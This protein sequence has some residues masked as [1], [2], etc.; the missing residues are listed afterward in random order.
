MSDRV[1]LLVELEY[2]AAKAGKKMT[3]SYLRPTSNN[4]NEYSLRF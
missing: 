1:G 3:D 2:V 4:D